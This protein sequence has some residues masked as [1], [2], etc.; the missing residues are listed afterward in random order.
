MQK[1]IA[2]IMGDGIGPEVTLQSV[3]I[4]D[5]VGQQF[6]HRFFFTYCMMGAEAI[7]KTGDPLPGE[8][9]EICL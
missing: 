3:K 8:T 4:L 2:V 6:G 5:A 9:L 1:K 7:E